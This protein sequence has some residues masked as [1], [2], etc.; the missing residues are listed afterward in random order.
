MGREGHALEISLEHFLFNSGLR[1]HDFAFAFE[2]NFRKLFS[3]QH[4]RFRC[5]ESWRRKIDPRKVPTYRTL[6]WLVKQIRNS[7][8]I[9]D[10]KYVVNLRFI[11]GTLISQFANP[12]V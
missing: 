10:S 2:A 7:N 8:C 5:Y 4:S 9:L 1:A 12:D 3:V 6:S 11:L